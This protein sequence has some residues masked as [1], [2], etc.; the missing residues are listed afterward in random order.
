[1]KLKNI[2]IS[3]FLVL[4]GK[5]LYEQQYQEQKK[6]CTF[7]SVV[8]N[9]NW[10]VTM[11]D[12]SNYIFKK[13]SIIVFISDTF[14]KN[15]KERLV[16]AAN[17]NINKDNYDCGNLTVYFER[18]GNIGDIEYL[19]PYSILMKKNSYI[20]PKDKINYFHL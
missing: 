5:E 14:P 9:V 12:V 15:E 13:K 18:V 3:L 1:M 20:V 8:S 19:Y 17:L 11:I 16:N 4:L 7:N 6:E 2:F 10:S